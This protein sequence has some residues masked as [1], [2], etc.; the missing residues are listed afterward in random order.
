[1][2]A[3]MLELLFREI[4]G[5]IDDELGNIETDERGK[6][7]WTEVANAQTHIEGRIRALTGRETDPT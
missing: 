3:D 5:I 7:D 1:M 6:C 2:K 4:F